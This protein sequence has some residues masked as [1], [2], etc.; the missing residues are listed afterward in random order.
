MKLFAAVLLF[1]ASAAFFAPSVNAD[2]VQVTVDISGK[3]GAKLDR[4]NA[5][6]REREQ[7]FRLEQP[8]N[9]F[10][11]RDILR[12][13]TRAG[14][15]TKWMNEAL[16]PNVNDLGL[17]EMIELLVEKHAPEGVHTVEIDLVQMSIPGASLAAW[18]G[19]THRMK[20][21]MR[22]LDE[23]GNVV[24]ETEYR[25]YLPYRNR[26]NIPYTGDGYIVQQGPYGTPAISLAAFW[27]LKALDRMYPDAKVPNLFTSIE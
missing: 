7:E 21:T 1:G 9:V 6:E 16:F 8:Q 5:I 25:A 17:T 14:E 19:V 13:R 22:E 18:R 4:G 11:A 10:L 12:L 26:V 2:T 3:F 23:D 24:H 15:S 20:G 27:T